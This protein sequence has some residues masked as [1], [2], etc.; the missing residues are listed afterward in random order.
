MIPHA[1]VTGA[2]SGIG[3]SIAE[4]LAQ[5]G[6]A[7]SLMGRREAPLQ[8]LEQQLGDGAAAISCDVTSE[9]AVSEAFNAARDKFGPISVLVNC[10]GAA[11]TTPFHKL[12]Y[13]SWQSTLD[14]NLSGVFLCTR[15][16]I[17]EMRTR[18]SGR[19][20]NIA[21]TASLKGY[22]YVSAYTAAKHGVLGL[23]RAL[24]LEV[25]T[26]GITVNAVC[27]GYTDTEIIGNAVDTIISKTGKNKADALSS[28]TATNPQK[29][30]IDPAE[31]AVTVIWLC[32]E[33][34]KGINGESISISGGEI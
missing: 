16:V 18:Q 24:A 33:G 4:A 27:P 10:A 20:I 32:S 31:V 30:L 23:T 8:V 19:I 13:A 11:P 22:A 34:A 28:F 1:V 21:S 25:A 17:D 15:A 6:Y 9:S 29:R 14:V 2:G 3:K 26:N 12:D 7:V 5:E